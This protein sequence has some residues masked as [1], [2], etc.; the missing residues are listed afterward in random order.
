NKKAELAYKVASAVLKL[1]LAGVR[2]AEQSLAELYK[3]QDEEA[4][5]AISAEVEDEALRNDIA[6]L[7]LLTE[8]TLKRLQEVEVV[9]DLGGYAAEVVGEPPL[10]ELA[11]QSTPLLISPASALL[12][13]M[14]GG[15][16]A[17]FI[18][19]S[20]RK[21][22][23]VAGELRARLGWPVLGRIPVYRP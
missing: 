23:P 14:L 20:R 15:G 6:R 13:L 18:P 2:T 17:L 22:F 10:G 5:K 7:Q 3:A 21:Q 19:A 11:L 4:Q 16:L 12:G 9:K 1:D 8:N